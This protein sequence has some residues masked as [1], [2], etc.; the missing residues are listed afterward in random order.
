MTTGQQ[1]ALAP[2]E[3]DEEPIHRPQVRPFR[4]RLLAALRHP[5]DRRE[6]RRALRTLS[7][8]LLRDLGL[9]PDDLDGL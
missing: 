9:H 5:I 4:Q 7:P 1:A 3:A 2:S 6:S 8:R